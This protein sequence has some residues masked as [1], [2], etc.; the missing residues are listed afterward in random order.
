MKE[1]VG[2]YLIGQLLVFQLGRDVFLRCQLVGV[3]FALAPFFFAVKFSHVSS[4]DERKQDQQEQSSS[5]LSNPVEAIN[6]VEH[7]AIQGHRENAV[8]GELVA[9]VEVVIEEN[10]PS[11]KGDHRHV[12]RAPSESFTPH[13]AVPHH[14]IVGIDKKPNARHGQNG[15]DVQFKQLINDQR[16]R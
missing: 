13:D 11:K 12:N 14:E 2:F 4:G 10:T 6:E 9:I 3:Q 8:H 1:V 15:V 16:N 7:E 5:Q